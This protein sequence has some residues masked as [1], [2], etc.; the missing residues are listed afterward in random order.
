MQSPS[1][2]F[3]LLF[4][5]CIFPSLQRGRRDEGRFP[6]APC[7]AAARVPSCYSPSSRLKNLGCVKTWGLTPRRVLEHSPERR[8]VYCTAQEFLPGVVT[9]ALNYGEELLLAQPQAICSWKRRSLKTSEPSGADL[10]FH[11]SGDELLQSSL[12]A[13]FAKAPASAERGVRDRRVKHVV[14]PCA[15]H[16]EAFFLPYGEEQSCTL[17]WRNRGQ[18]FVFSVSFLMPI[19]R[20]LGS[21]V[22]GGWVPAV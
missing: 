12:M 21:R 10:P 15:P 8:R 18:A 3:A 13:A 14:L 1:Q 2:C 7:L 4:G 5:F 6:A 20:C 17:S 16:R 22:L 19:L 9:S 11:I